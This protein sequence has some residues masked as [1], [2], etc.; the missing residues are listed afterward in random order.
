MSEIS[1]EL[2]NGNVGKAP[3]IDY[4]WLSCADRLIHWAKDKSTGH[5][6]FAFD[7]L[8]SLAYVDTIPAIQKNFKSFDNLPTPYN[9]HFGFINLCSPLYLEHQ[10]WCYQKAAKPKSGAIGKLTS[11][12][13]LRFIEILH[14]EFVSVKSI[15]GNGIADAFLKHSD[16]RIILCEI[17]AAPLTTYPFLFQL[18]TEQ[19][20]NFE[21]LTRTQVENVNSALY[22]HCDDPIPL[23]KP[24]DDLWPFAPAIDFV[25]NP[26]NAD[27]VEQYVQVWEAI[28]S[29]YINKDR[30]S[31]YYYIANA[32]G[33][34]PRIA[35]DEH[36]WPGSE[37]ISDSK[38]SAGLDR[39]DDIKKGIYQTFKLSIESNR[40]YPE[41]DIKTA[42]VSNLPA[43]RHGDDYIT[44]FYDV[45]WGFESSFSKVEE[46]QQ[47][48]ICHKDK[49][50]RPFDYIIAL[51]NA[52]TRDE[53]L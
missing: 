1:E 15:G 44:P 6:A 46:E 50:N 22:M 16:G 24:M 17:K 30:T 43:Y 2:I 40:D 53:L 52:F 29:A 37:S 49:L 25:T 26:S 19:L 48:Y 13:I 21:Q 32:S 31:P 39:T 51:E 28:R 10:E 8:M 27:K 3:L 5:R 36:N 7:F 4:P 34:P 47:L 11:E 9:V 20:L 41:V 45:Y 33:K 38:T 14:D 35:K 12:I 23:G 42:L 18:P